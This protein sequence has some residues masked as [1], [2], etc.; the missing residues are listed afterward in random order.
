[1]VWLPDIDTQTKLINDNSDSTE[2]CPD[3]SQS[4]GNVTRV[5]LVSL[6]V[7]S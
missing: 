7:S 5:N 4:S 6:T 1:M 2:L 3:D